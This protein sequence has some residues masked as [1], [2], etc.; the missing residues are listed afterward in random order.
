M[1]IFMSYLRDASLYFYDRTR[2]L[3]LHSP[4]EGAVGNGSFTIRTFSSRTTCCTTAYRL[5]ILSLHIRGGL[6]QVL[7]A[8]T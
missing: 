7:N 4:Q 2:F 3:G 6:F 1:A 5:T 8:L